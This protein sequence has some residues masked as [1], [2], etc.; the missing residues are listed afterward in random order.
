MQQRLEERRVGEVVVD[1]QVRH[2]D[3]VAQAA[4]LIALAAG[5]IVTVLGLVALLGIDWDVASLDS[6]V[7]DIG[8]MTFTPV[9]AGATAFLGLLLLAAAA[10]RNGEGK[11]ALGALTGCLGAAVLLAD[12]EPSW[13]VTEAQGWV[14]VAVGLVFVIAGVLDRNDTVVSRRQQVIDLR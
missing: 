3:G 1:D 14:L 2:D 9:V 5:A 12:L 11:V 6:P 4:R 8:D 7:T 13:H 10:S